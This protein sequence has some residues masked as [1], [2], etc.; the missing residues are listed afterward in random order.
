MNVACLKCIQWNQ[1]KITKRKMREF[2]GDIVYFTTYTIVAVPGLGSAEINHNAEFCTIWLNQTYPIPTC[3]ST[4]YFQEQEHTKLYQLHKYTPPPQKKKKKK[5]KKN[6]NIYI[7][8][9]WPA[10]CI[11]CMCSTFQFMS[12][13]KIF[14]THYR[15][16]IVYMF[17]LENLALKDSRN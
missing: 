16:W 14:L 2:K 15:Q 5:K 17:P 9:P 6:E 13:Q 8:H 11:Q 3:K 7:P 12:K 4:R 10:V 1:H